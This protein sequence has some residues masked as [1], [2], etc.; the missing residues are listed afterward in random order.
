MPCYEQVKIE[1]AL[2]LKDR[3]LLEE[4]VKAIGATM[5]GNKVSKGAFVF[6]ISEDGRASAQVAAVQQETAKKVLG[7]LKRQYTFATLKN[8]AKANRF[9]VKQAG[10]KLVARRWS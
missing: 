7:E 4:A 3:R 9:N 2:Q 6:T 8:W 10:D 5:T 1:V